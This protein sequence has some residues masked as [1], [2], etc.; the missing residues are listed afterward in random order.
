[1]DLLLV[2]GWLLYG[3]VIGLISKSIYRG[4]VPTG[5]VSTLLVGVVGSFVGGFIRFLL[6]GHGD[7]FQPSGILMGVLGGVVA[8]YIHKKLL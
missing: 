7:P 5:F 2:L 8:C 6:T 1:M 3:L 4:D